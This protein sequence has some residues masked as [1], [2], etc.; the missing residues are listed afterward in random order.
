[1]HGRLSYKADRPSRAAHVNMSAHE[2]V[3][4]VVGRSTFREMMIH[5]VLLNN[6]I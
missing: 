1:M 5:A 4:Q 3:E 6:A 2:L